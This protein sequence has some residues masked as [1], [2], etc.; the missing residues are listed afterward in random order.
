M[1]EESDLVILEAPKRPRLG[2]DVNAEEADLE[3]TENE[4]PET[5]LDQEGEDSD[6]PICFEPWTCNGK[7]RVVSLKCG[8]LFGRQCI[9]RWINNP[10]SRKLCPTCKRKSERADI[11]DL[12]VTRKITAIDTIQIEKLKR[13]IEME[14]AMRKIAGDR[15][16][17]AQLQLQ[18]LKAEILTLK[19]EM[20]RVRIE[21]M[22]KCNDISSL[23]TIKFWRQLMISPEGSCRGLAI[24]E[25][26][27]AAL[28]GC[29]SIQ[30]GIKRHGV[31]Q[32]SLADARSTLFLP[33]HERPVR[34]VAAMDGQVASV[35]QD[36]RLCL[37]SLA[38]GSMVLSA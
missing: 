19:E 3:N 6:C 15:E 8:H 18:S 13:E 38:S 17:M 30:Q 32:V 35:G 9:E 33:G 25:G 28:I 2:E 10:A 12:Y 24:E 14:R 21:R 23:T 26:Q 29:H 5:P 36:G 37:Y 16:A 34:G 31:M 11:R 27:R 7:H 4:Q 1:E 22:I 20:A